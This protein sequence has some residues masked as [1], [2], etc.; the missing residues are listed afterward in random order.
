MTGRPPKPTRLRLLEGNR[1]KCPVR[2]G[3][4]PPRGAPKIPPGM[5]RSARREWRVI[6]AALDSLGVLAVTDALAIRLLAE[7]LG[8]YRDARRVID[9]EG[10]TYEC[11]TRIGGTMHRARPESAIAAD[12]WRRASALMSRFGL[13]PA[14]RVRLGTVPERS[15][16]AG[17]VP[18][19]AIREAARTEGA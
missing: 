4:E 11:E 10:A 14:D 9:R 19:D 12:A 16:D 17:S 2:V 1:G 18:T 13:T 8:E 3:P 5:S 15:R 6:V 7:A